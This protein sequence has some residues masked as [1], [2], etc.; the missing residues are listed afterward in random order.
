MS[1]TMT[2]AP[3]TGSSTVTP[4]LYGMLYASAGQEQHSNLEAGAL[5]PLDIY[6]RNAATVAKSARAA[7]M[8][9]SLVT[10]DPARIAQILKRRGLAG[11]IELTPHNFTL[12]VPEGIPFRSAHFKLDLIDAF[13]RGEYGDFVGLIDIDLVICEPIR[14]DDPNA[15]Y[16]YDIWAENP[17]C[18]DDAAH[19]ANLME[20]LGD[21]AMPTQW[22]GGEFIVG[23]RDVFARLSAEI[24]AMW[25]TY[26]AQVGKWKHV[27]DEMLVN[28]AIQKLM[29][30]G[31]RIVNAGPEGLGMVVR[32][33][34]RRTNGK[35]RPWTE[36]AKCAIMH[37]PG[38]K[39]FLATIAEHGFDKTGFLVAHRKH[40]GRRARIAQVRN[41]IDRMRFRKPPYAPQMR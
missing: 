24:K 13:G 17:Y 19:V 12:D 29:R 25:P 35:M 40:A 23:H 31:G 18:E 26:I 20:L 30:Q 33:W 7:G 8:E 2:L 10:N 39:Q 5:D 3:D 9:F 27:G 1:T 6:V 38:D 41:L 4:H 37:L 28:A 16:V 36:A 11:A 34:S 14:C 15:L 21:G 22:F 32:W